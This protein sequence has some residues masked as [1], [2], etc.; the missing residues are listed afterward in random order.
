MKIA[1]IEQNIADIRH[2]KYWSV[3]KI[4]MKL[5]SSNDINLMYGLGL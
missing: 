1:R 5:R 3:Y 2:V 4:E